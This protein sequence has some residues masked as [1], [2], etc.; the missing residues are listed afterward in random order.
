[1]TA[2]AVLTLGYGPSG[3]AGAVL[4]LG[5][6]IG[7]FVPPQPPSVVHG[8]ARSENPIEVHHVSL[9]VS[10]GGTAR[11]MARKEF[12]AL[13]PEQQAMLLMILAN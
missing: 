8:T 7:S 11:V 1:M 5:Y 9:R 4:K 3:S 12:E 2:G 10:G 13:P 6:G